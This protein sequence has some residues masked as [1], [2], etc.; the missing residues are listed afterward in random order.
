LV[1]RAITVEQAVGA[2]W[3]VADPGRR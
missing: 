3:L 1:I 2:D